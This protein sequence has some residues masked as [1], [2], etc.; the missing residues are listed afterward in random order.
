MDGREI[1]ANG[2]E[3][4]DDDQKESI[5]RIAIAYYTRYKDR[6]TPSDL[7]AAIGY[8]R[9]A[10]SARKIDDMDYAYCLFDLAEQLFTQYLHEQGSKEG[11][12]SPVG[13][14]LNVD[15]Q[16]GK[17]D[18]DLYDAREAL[19]QVLENVANLEK[20]LITNSRKLLEVVK[21][22]IDGLSNSSSKA[23]SSISL[24]LATN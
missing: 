19:E 4:V 3:D 15:T 12:V 13:E 24:T 8:N 14:A 10:R 1:L 17:G 7:E 11:A 5:L 23:A 16:T 2:P 18:K 22:H 20:D 21:K 6:R 9:K